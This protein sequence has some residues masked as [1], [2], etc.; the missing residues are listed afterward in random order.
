MGQSSWPC[1]CGPLLVFEEEYLTC[2]GCSHIFEHS[3]HGQP[4]SLWSLDLSPF[5]NVLVRFLWVLVLMCGFAGRSTLQWAGL[6][7]QGSIRH[8]L[9]H[10]TWSARAPSSQLKLPK[11]LANGWAKSQCRDPFLLK[12]KNTAYMWVTN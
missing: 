3:S 4:P 2:I 1:S 8:M 11:K 9:S 10:P 6:K 7:N 12:K 5:P